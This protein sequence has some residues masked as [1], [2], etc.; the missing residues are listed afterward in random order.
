MKSVQIKTTGMSCTGCEGLVKE[1]VSALDG[2]K[3]VKPSFKKELV[4]V[5]FDET[6]TN[7]EDIKA[8]IKEA[9]YKPE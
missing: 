9:G 2:V 4:E 5:K 6:K 1:M 7:A 3:T 8:K